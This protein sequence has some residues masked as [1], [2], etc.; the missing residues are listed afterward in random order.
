MT[1]VNAAIRIDVSTGN[2]EAKL[3]SLGASLD[4]LNG[5]GRGVAAA[6]DNLAGTFDKITG[7]AGSAASATGKIGTVLGEVQ[8]RAAGAI[9]VVGNLLSKLMAFGPSGA[10]IAAVALGIAAIGTAA[11]KAAAQVEVWKANLLTMTKSTQA[12]DAAYRGLVQFAAATPFS[13]EQSVSGFTKLRALGLA[14]STDIMTSYG[15]TAAAMGKNMSQMI[16]A[17]ADAT[18]GEFE[19]L[20][21][22]G[23]KAKQ[24]GDKVAFTF[25]GV[26]KTVSK[27]ATDIQKYIV[28]IG[29]VNFGGAM[30]RQMAT[31]QGAFSNLEDQIFNTLAAMG[32]GVLNQT[33]GKITSAVSSGLGAITP[34]LSGIMDVIG[35]ILSAVWEVGA[36]LLSMFTGGA[37]GASNFKTGLDNLAVVF[38]FIG[39]AASIF[40]KVV[41]S[42]FSFIGNIIGTVIGGIQSGFSSLFNWLVPVTGNAGQSMGESFVGILRAASYVAG[43]LPNIFAV[44]L[45]E[46]KSMFA[47]AGAALA[48]SLTGD[49]SKWGKVDLSFGRTQKVVGT[50]MKGAGRIQK[51]Q[52]GNRAW[53]DEKAGRN[54]GGNINFGAAPAG[55]NAGNKGA[56]DKGESEAEKRAKQEKEFWETLKNQAATAALLP[57]AAEDFNKQLELQKILGRDLNAGEKERLSTAT[58][59]VR[60]NQ[61]VTDALDAHNKKSLELGQQEELFAKQ[62]KGMTDE[63]AAVEKEVY[64]FRNEALAKGVDLQSEAYKAAEATVRA[65]AA[66]GVQLDKNNEKLAKARQLAADGFNYAKDAI[67][68]HGSIAD[69]QGVAKSDYQKNLDGL[70]AAFNSTDPEK[71]ISAAEFQAGVKKAGEDFKETMAEIGDAFSNKM[72]NI[73]NLLG[74]IGS[75]IGGKVGS[76]LD[77]AGNVANSVGNFSKTQGDIAGKFDKVFGKSNSPFIKGIGKA[78]GG[79]VAGSEVGAEVAKFGKMISS[80]FSTTGSQLGGALGGAAF[81]PIGSLVGSILGG[82]IGGLL[83]KTK[84]GTSAVVNGVITTKG[85]DSASK[86]GS[87]SAANSI[88]SGLDAIAEQLGASADGDYAVSIGQYKGKWRVSRK[89]RTGSLK[90]GKGR[91]D[92][93]DFGKDGAEEALQYAIADAI[94]DGAVTGLRATTEAIIKQKGDLNAQLTKALKFEGVFKELQQRTNPVAA[95]VQALNMEFKSLNK[96]FKEA[97]ATSEEY[98]Q[99]EQL[100]SLKLKEIIEQQTSGFQGILDSL[101]GDAGGYSTVAQLNANIGKMAQFRS[102]IAA[103]KTVDQDKFTSLMESIINGTNDIYGANS[104]KGQAILADVGSLTE[105]AMANVV[106]EFDKTVA[107]GEA[108]VNAIQKQTDAYVAQ[109]QE[110]NVWLKAIAEKLEVIKNAKGGL[111]GLSAAATG[112]S[113]N[114]N[115][116]V[117][118]VY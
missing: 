12:A 108:Q 44:A 111:M 41:G 70:N 61:F 81:G 117:T 39:E 31:A 65:D 64:K 78:V 85:N 1:D 32:D 110:S 34:L 8:G 100:R 38:A 58:Q 60:T 26:T 87:A 2:A 73:G 19:R 54:Q 72:K 9:P 107:A 56:K 89:G 47:S 24:S 103:G 104:A 51:D 67:K 18:T 79:A 52:R 7:K 33:I 93:K 20:K 22:F 82:A 27:N 11:V 3:K 28:D 17:V 116:K 80:K 14:T 13:L 36:G 115:G 57:L 16:E 4:S 43:Q 83:K 76:V 21:E 63:Q 95:A 92:I 35:G 118:T 68:T 91:E 10:I 62:L 94:R 6:N 25:Q 5:K 105:K 40:G 96:I 55:P 106:G 75:R 29:K 88:V 42:V 86:K 71:K 101:K 69:R 50:V 30:A 53:I 114:V 109:Q 15:N 59:L 45:A 113:G 66:R 74:D 102:D 37:Q 112:Q 84:Y 48:A 99:M 97:N 49:F 98:A 46:L 90:G 23:I 77:K